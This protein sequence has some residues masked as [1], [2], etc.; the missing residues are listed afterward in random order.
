MCA[1]LG[2]G[3]IAG[4]QSSP[5]NY[6]KKPAKLAACLAK[7]LMFELAL[8]ASHPARY[9][10]GSLSFAQK[11]QNLSDRNRTSDRWM[12]LGQAYYSP[13]LYQLSYRELMTHTN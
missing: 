2:L 11:G 13:P 3:P 8:S 6:M 4:H 12:T 5:N 10:F 7:N 9:H 1:A